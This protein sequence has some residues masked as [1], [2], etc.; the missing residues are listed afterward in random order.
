MESFKTNS[1]LHRMHKAMLKYEILFK[2]KLPISLASILFAPK[3]VKNDLTLNPEYIYIR[4]KKIT[5]KI[6]NS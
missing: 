1:R 6:R 2:L 3:Y 4:M 5:I